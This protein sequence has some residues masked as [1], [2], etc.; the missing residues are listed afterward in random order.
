MAREDQGAARHPEV[1]AEVTRY[2]GANLA[3]QMGGDA[4]LVRE[5]AARSDALV[6]VEARTHDNQPIDIKAILGPNWWVG[7]D[8][9][10]A[11]TAGT[12]IAIRKGGP[13]K[14]RRLVGLLRLVQISGPGSKVQ[15][16]YLRSVPISDP[17]GN[18][19]LFGVHIPLA[20]TGQQDE[21]IAVVGEAWR[22]TSGR[23]LL[24]ADCNTDPAGFAADVTAPHHDGDHVM[25]WL[26][27]RGW[28]N[29][30]AYWR[31]RRGSDHNVGTFRTD[32]RP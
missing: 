29:V 18:A 15:A 5:L 8:L 20:S 6:F 12:A 9:R 16:R 2:D 28:E 22:A 4:R 31:T 27:S 14:R 3:W 23:K 17:E 10:N 7:Q 32:D 13:V 24:F 30:R 21:A 26:W 1:A 25:V 11:A 19:T